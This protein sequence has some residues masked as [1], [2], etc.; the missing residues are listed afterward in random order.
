[1]YTSWDST[2]F[3]FSICLIKA[4]SLGND[5]KTSFF[6]VVGL[7]DLTGSLPTTFT[8]LNK[9]EQL[10]ICKSKQEK[11]KLILPILPNEAAASHCANVVVIVAAC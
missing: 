3:D 2:S 4:V 1:M 5:G 7:N 8:Q 9:I 6:F 11:M 10:H